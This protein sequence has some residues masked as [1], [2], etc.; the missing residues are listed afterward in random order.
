MEEK[1][2]F[3]LTFDFQG[4]DDQRDFDILSEALDFIQENLNSDQYGNFAIFQRIQFR[5]AVFDV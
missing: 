5:I 3:I 2:E 4:G 1:K